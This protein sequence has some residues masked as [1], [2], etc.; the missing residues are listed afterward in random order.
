[1][2]VPD[3]DEIVKRAHSIWE[4]EGRPEGRAEEHWKMAVAEV[5][6]EAEAKAKAASVAESKAKAEP[7]PAKK[8]SPSG[9][10]RKV[11]N[12]AAKTKP[13]EEA[14]QLKAPVEKKS[15]VEKKPAKSPTKK[16]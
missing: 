4:R 11:E 3:H 15:P 8:A 5:T 2:S 13:S 9:P 12:Q 14:G 10:A 7:E 1:M 6:A 16:R